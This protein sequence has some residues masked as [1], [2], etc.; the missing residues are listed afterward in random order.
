MIYELK[1]IEA[2]LSSFLGN[3]KNEINEDTQ[4][5]FPCPRCIEENGIKEAKKYNLE[6]NLQKQV[7]NCW[8]CSSVHDEMHGS[9]LKLIKLYGNETIL[10]EYK[11]LIK[12]LK[13]NKLY[14]LHY[15]CDDF[16]IE[17]KCEN[18]SVKLPINYH[19]I[20][21]YDGLIPNQVI[22]YLKSRNINQEIINEFNIGFT[23]FDKNNIKTSNR[24][25]IPSYNEFDELNYWT[26]R[27]YDN[28]PHA[29]KYYNPTIERKNIIFNENKI[30]WDCDITLVEG[31]FDHIVTPNSIPL[32]G[33]KIK[34]DFKIY[35]K[36][37]EKA[38]AKVN[39][40][41]D[42]DA[43]NDA[44]EIYKLLNHDKLY[45]KIR[46]IPVDNALDPSKIYELYGYK[47]IIEHLKNAIKIKEFYLL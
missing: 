24:I 33:K 28:Y 25:I 37:M 38:N 32:L 16:N 30:Q 45:N 12:T 39:I 44:I 9:I 41:L 7:F 5:Q 6:V 11:S 3:P 46:L 23:T 34:T 47:G 4:L 15:S 19:R 29:Q 26:G 27:N 40:F 17:R 35:E 14:N 20:N 43:E 8:K 2:L 36:L 21:G 10:N 18:P 31:P 42:G 1:Q 13:E 22:D